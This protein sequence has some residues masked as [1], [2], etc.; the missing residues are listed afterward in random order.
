MRF[1]VASLLAAAISFGAAQTASAADMAPAPV[2]KA[3][4][5]VMVAPPMNWT[6]FYVG[7]FFGGGWEHHTTT[8]TGSLNSVNFPY[9]YSS[10]G[11]ISGVLG[12]LQ[13]GYD[14]Q[15]HPNWLLGITGDWGWTDIKGDQDNVAVTSSSIV[16]HVH[17]EYTWLATVSGRL[18]FVASND[19]LLYLKGGGAWA[20]AKSN[21]NVTNGSGVIT[22]T[23]DSSTTRSGWLIGAGTEYR[24][25]RN[26]SAFLEYNYIDFGT[27]TISNNVTLGSGSVPTGSV[28]LR[29]NKSYL[30]IVK[31]GVN[32]RF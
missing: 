23:T 13:A 10:S 24:F 1:K 21:S 16:N 7:A 28:L 25:A 12:G 31:A 2:Y 5:P 22:T 8:N 17:H 4:P 32:Y 20:H 27:E 6:G 14:W 19:W 9:G 18:G 30:N 15:F 29:D 11:T 26:W 3:P